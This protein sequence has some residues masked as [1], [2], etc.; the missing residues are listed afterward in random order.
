MNKVFEKVTIRRMELKN[1]LMMS[2]MVTNYS[3]SEGQVTDRLIAY[4]RERARGGVGMIETEAAYVHPSGKGYANQLGIYKDNLIPGLKRLV[5]NIHACGA[6]ATIQLHHAGRRTSKSLTGWEVVSPSAI[7]CFEGD[8]PPKGMI[9]ADDSG[10]TLPK[11]MTQA[12]IA[13]M[14]GLL[15][16]CRS[17]GQEGRF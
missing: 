17:P 3:T 5:Q 1:R 15:F 9:I 16:Q 12:E 2:A 10:G 7:A 13:Q 4:H 6:K 11:E 14:V 8:T